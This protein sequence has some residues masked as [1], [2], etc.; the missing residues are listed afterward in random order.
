MY[1]AR[2]ASDP[3]TETAPSRPAGTGAT[4]FRRVDVHYEPV[5]W[6]DSAVRFGLI[7]LDSDHVSERELRYML[8]ADA[9][10]LFVTRVRHGG[11]C[12]LQHLAAMSDELAR[13]A[14]L[15]LPGTGVDV[16]AYG[17]TSGTVAIGI[18]TVQRAIDSACP[19]TPVTT[20]IT[21]ARTALEALGARRIVM[22]TP[23]IDEVNEMLAEHLARE[24]VD[25][26]TLASFGLHT[27]IE[28]TS[29][30]QDALAQ[31]AARLD[32]TGAEALFICCTA[33]R[34]AR[35]IEPIERSLGLPVISS[36]QAMVW[37]MLRLA[38][39]RD[40]VHGFGRL[41]EMPR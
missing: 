14:S 8:P 25:V 32:L 16:I 4:R 20:P 35:V 18:D 26:L 15:L 40:P 31:A 5:L 28:I 10:E 11:K 22:L 38:G 30:P 9:S 19:G 6:P 33:L 36:N 41:L 7:A 17:C 27:D 34:T 37:D 12:D 13:A 24:G 1:A 21:A 23:Y 39:Y 3:R 2:M 29:V